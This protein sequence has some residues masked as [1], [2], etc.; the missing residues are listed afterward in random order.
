MSAA[1][2]SAPAAADGTE[3]EADWLA[4]IEQARRQGNH[5][6]VYDLAQR[7]LQDWPDTIAFEH[8]A[9]LAL[10]RAGATNNAPR[11]L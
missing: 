11:A 7:A 4:R 3:P 6:L 1:A 2:Q 5:L 10:A 8:Q 9:I